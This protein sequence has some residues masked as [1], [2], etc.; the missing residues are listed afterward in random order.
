[1]IPFSLCELG[2]EKLIGN[3]D[4]I[5]EIKSDGERVGVEIDV[6]GK[7]TLWN[8]R[9][10]VKNASFPE[11]VEAVGKLKLKD[12]QMDGEMVL[13]VDGK[14]YRIGVQKRSSSKNTR[15]IQ[16]LSRRKPMV[17]RIFDLLKINGKDISTSP[18]SE[19]KHHLNELLKGE[20][21]LEYV[22]SF[23]DTKALW[24][25]A[26]KEDLEGLVL[27]RK[28]SIYEKNTRSSLWLKVKR[29]QFTTVRY[30][31]YETHPKGITLTNAEGHRVSC[32]G[33]QHVKVKERIDQQGFADV[34]IQYLEM[35]ENGMYYEPSFKGIKRPDFVV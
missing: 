31:G 15:L 17:Y 25:R 14:D 5:G 30:N 23:E 4:Y 7:V 20:T 13:L 34:V 22:P 24:D 26:N 16:N 12:T 9:G 27:K 11:I 29:F 21:I 18:L 33:K 2:N 1:M 35:T 3:P 6:N 32:S 8:R 10:F 19:R 28:D